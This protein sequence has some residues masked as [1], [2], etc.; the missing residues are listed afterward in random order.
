M[1][2]DDRQRPQRD[3][4]WLTALS[5]NRSAADVRTPVENVPN[6]VMQARGRARRALEDRQ[7]ERELGLL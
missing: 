6:P 7:I 5:R 1:S 3:S 4:T 2:R